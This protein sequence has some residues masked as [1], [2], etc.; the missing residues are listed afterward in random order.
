MMD[1]AT[2]NEQ[3]LAEACAA[4]MWAAD[5][6]SAG[7]G[8]KLLRVSRGKSEVSMPI[9]QSMVNGHNTCHGGFIFALADSAFAFACNTYNQR[10]VAQSC[11]I[12]YTAPS[13]LGDRLLA[14]AREVSRAGRSGIYDVEITREDG[15]KIAEF[16]G[17]CRTI[18]GVILENTPA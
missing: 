4:A 14:R 2:M 11:H 5:D 8:M 10:C 12:T 6:A 3:K 9:T 7:L 1:Q 17:L 15:T 16:R 18:K 13:M